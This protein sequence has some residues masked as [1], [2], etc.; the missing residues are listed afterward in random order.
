MFTYFFIWVALTLLKN[1]STCDK[2]LEH[3]F[4]CVADDSKQ[5][6]QVSNPLLFLNYVKLSFVFSFLVL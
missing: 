5:Q 3:D 2:L 4:V 6:I 1:L